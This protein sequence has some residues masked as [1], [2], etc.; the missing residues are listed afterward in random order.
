[1]RRVE[2]PADGED[3]AMKTVVHLVRRHLRRDSK[4]RHGAT[5]RERAR[6][7]EREGPSDAR[8]KRGARRAFDFASDPRAF[9]IDLQRDDRLAGG[10]EGRS[11]PRGIGARDLRKSAGE[12]GGEIDRRAV[13]DG[14]ED[15]DPGFAA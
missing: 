14:S 15:G 4:A 10:T 6:A 3:L 5:R 7:E 11:R 9:S 1:L 12:G 13:A 2:A 8:S